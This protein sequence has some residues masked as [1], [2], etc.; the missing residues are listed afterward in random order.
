MESI[1]EI[2]DFTRDFWVVEDLRPIL[3]PPLHNITST[4]HCQLLM[5]PPSCYS[6][7]SPQTGWEHQKFWLLQSKTMS[8]CLTVRIDRPFGDFLF[9]IRSF[10]QKCNMSGQV[11]TIIQHRQIQSSKREGGSNLEHVNHSG[12]CCLAVRAFQNKYQL[13]SNIVNKARP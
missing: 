8:H 12:I 2:R 11:I 9:L 6:G 1:G 7:K 13:P 10:H 5:I 4:L 3:A